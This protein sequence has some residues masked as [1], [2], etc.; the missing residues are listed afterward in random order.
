VYAI[1]AC[2]DESIDRNY[3]NRNIYILSD[4]QAAIKALDKYQITSKLVWGCHQ[5]ITQLTTHNRFQLI[6]VPGHEGIVGNETADQLTK[7]GSE[8]L[9]IGLEPACAISV[10]IAKKQSG[11]GLTEIINNIGSLQLDSERQR[12]SYKGPL[13][14]ERRI[15]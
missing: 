10:G 7:T 2:A 15:C 8:H 11:T 4:I 14:E 3:K 12:D 6:W 9:F 13:L 5:S 1:K